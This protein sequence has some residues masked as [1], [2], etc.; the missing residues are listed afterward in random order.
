MFLFFGSS[1]GREN[2]TPLACAPIEN[3]EEGE[4]NVAAE[5]TVACS[6]IAHYWSVGQN[7]DSSPQDLSGSLCEHLVD[8]KPK[9]Q[10]GGYNVDVTC[11][12]GSSRAVERRGLDMPKSLLFILLVTGLLVTV[13]EAQDYE[14]GTVLKSEMRPYSQSDGTAGNQVVYFIQSGS[15]VYQIANHSTKTEM[16]VGQKIRYRVGKNHF[17]LLSENNKET[18]YEIV[19]KK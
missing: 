19:G 14:T 4:P 16:T 7:G 18:K 15:A 3:H 9:N 2:G 6:G 8:W 1:S 11:H 13:S 10:V 5:D 17:Y 12:Y